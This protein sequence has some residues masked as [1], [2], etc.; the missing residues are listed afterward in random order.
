VL[1]STC[2]VTVGLRDG[3]L[4][5]IECKVSNSATNSV[6]RL[7]REVGDKV[8]SWRHGYGERAITAVVLAG[9]FK[10]ANLQA[11]QAGGV[12]LFWEHA[13]GGLADFLSQAV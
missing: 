10:A 8:K 11:A 2:D 3:R 9:V 12:V 6:K 13:L 5:L 7:D 4:L 1:D